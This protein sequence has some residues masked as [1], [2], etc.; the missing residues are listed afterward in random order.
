MKIKKR[1]ESLKDRY[2]RKSAHFYGTNKQRLVERKLLDEIDQK[3]SEFKPKLVSEETIAYLRKS[4]RS[5]QV[6][7][8][9]EK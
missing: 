7:L 8:L 5:E 3:V 1:N 6:A 4:R 2:E 9:Y